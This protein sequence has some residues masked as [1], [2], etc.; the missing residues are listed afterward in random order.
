M[1]PNAYAGRPERQCQTPRGVW[2]CQSYV[3]L[4]TQPRVVLCR[5]FARAVMDIRKYR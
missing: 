2:G 1:K 5:D 4:H 3:A